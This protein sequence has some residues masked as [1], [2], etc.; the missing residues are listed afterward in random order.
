[1]YRQQ[2]LQN[3]KL[4]H[5]KVQRNDLGI[6]RVEYVKDLINNRLI[7]LLESNEGIRGDINIHIDG[8]TLIIQGMRD[9]GYNRPI[10]AHLLQDELLQEFEF[11][12]LEVGFSDI[13]LMKGYTYELLSSTVIG[14]NM[15]RIILEYKPVRKI[16]RMYH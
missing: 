13:N 2:H 5:H 14:Q 9:L 4:N 6:D 15:M 3:H 1:M 8:S 16:E 11:G 10:R 12:G 7:I